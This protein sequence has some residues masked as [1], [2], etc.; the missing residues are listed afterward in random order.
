MSVIARMNAT[1]VKRGG[2]V[3]R[4]PERITAGVLLRST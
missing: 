2:V 1:L 4:L 3:V